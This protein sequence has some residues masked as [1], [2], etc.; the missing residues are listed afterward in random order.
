M[1]AGLS[2][3]KSQFDLDNPDD[4][5]VV[6]PAVEKIDHVKHVFLL[7]RDPAATLNLK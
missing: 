4:V 3:A 6:S 2:A 5:V 1:D 7:L